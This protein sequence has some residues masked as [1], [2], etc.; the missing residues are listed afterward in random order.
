MFYSIK[1]EDKIMSDRTSQYNTNLQDSRRQRDEAMDEVN[2]LHRE[3]QTMKV[4]TSISAAAN[5]LD[6]KNP[7]HAAMTNPTAVS[8]SIRSSL[9]KEFDEKKSLLEQRWDHALHLVTD[10][11]K[12]QRDEQV[13][14][15]ISKFDVEQRLK[16]QAEISKGL[17]RVEAAARQEVS[18]LTKL[19]LKMHSTI[20]SQNA[21]I[22]KLTDELNEIRGREET[23]KKIERDATKAAAENV[24][25]KELEF[26]RVKKKLGQSNVLI[27]ELQRQVEGWKAKSDGDWFRDRMAEPGSQVSSRYS[28]RREGGGGGGGR[29]WLS[30]STQLVSEE[31]ISRN[32]RREA[33]AL[34]NS[35]AKASSSTI[36]PTSKVVERQRKQHDA[37]VLGI[38]D[39]ISLVSSAPSETEGACAGVIGINATATSDI[40]GGAMNRRDLSTDTGGGGF[41]GDAAGGGANRVELSNTLSPAGVAG[42]V[43][44]PRLDALLQSF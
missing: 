14:L 12:K 27:E 20:E 35:M 29:D 41:F 28:P 9:Q 30:K 44:H 11:M 4:K 21:K 24:V 18:D 40:S 15:A 19:A 26:E 8:N 7:Q 39:D 6:S 43:G 32:R 16:F 1:D 42:Q 17:E 33:V 31:E 10:Q 34:A 5:S 13:A 25:E 3:I 2:R 23:T 38:A 36:P 37:R 22:T